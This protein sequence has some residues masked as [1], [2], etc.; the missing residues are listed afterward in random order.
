MAATTATTLPNVRALSPRSTDGALQPPVQSQLAGCCARVAKGSRPPRP[1]RRVM[2]RYPAGRSGK[3]PF[4]A[5]FH[6]RCPGGTRVSGLLRREAG[7]APF[8]PFVRGVGRCR[9]REGAKEQGMQGATIVLDDERLILR[10]R[11]A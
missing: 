5:L 1:D 8:R 2:D 9:S 7:T 10:G 4:N 3:P 6:S 11:L